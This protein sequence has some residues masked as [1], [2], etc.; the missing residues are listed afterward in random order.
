MKNTDLHLHS[1]YSDGELSPAEV[2][3]A[4]K[5]KGVKNLALTDHNSIGGNKEA[6]EEGEKIG[7]KVIPG[8]EIVGEEDEVLGYFIDYENEEFQEELVKISQKGN[9]KEDL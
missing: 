4:A 1:Y 8:I 7:V 9:E 5:K 2:V 3:R 6:I